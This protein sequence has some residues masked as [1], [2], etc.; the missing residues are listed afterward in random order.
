MPSWEPAIRARMTSLRLTSAREQEIVDELSQHLEDLWR[1][2]VA[3]GA[4]A[5][6]ATR[7][8]LEDFS[9]Q[10]LLA[11][12]LKPLR[13]SN[14]PAATVPAA[15]TGHMFSDLW[16][17]V[18]YAV[19]TL[20]KQ[21]SF[22]VAAVLTLA[23]G[24]GANAAVFSIVN[25]VLIRPLPYPDSGRL[26]AVYSRYQPATGFDFPYFPLSGPEFADLRNRVRSFSAI[27]AYAGATR[28]VTRDGAT[29]ERVVTMRVTAPFFDVLGVQP[30]RGR[31]FT[32]EE[33]QRTE[34][35]LA[36]LAYD[37]ADPTG[38]AVGSTIRLDDAPCE[39][40]GVMPRGFVFRDE[41]VRV[42]TTLFVNAQETPL[43]RQSHG[44]TAVA[45]LRDGVTAEQADAELK[46]VW[47]YWSQIYAEHY[48]KGHFA[49]LRP[50]HE[51]IVGGQ[52]NALVVLGGAVVFV[53]LIVCVNISALLIS[54][55]EARRREI[56]VRHALGANRRRLVR[57]LV[58]EAMV[59]AGVGGTA[60]LLVANLLLQALLALSPQRQ[61]AT[62]PIVLDYVTFGYAGL[63]IILAGFFIGIIPALSATGARMQETLRVDSRT[64]T[65]SLRVLVARSLLV[66]GQLA[67]SV[68]LL[69]G[70]LLL[71]RS[72]QDL[73]R[74]DLGISPD[75]LLTFSVSVPPGRQL[76]AAA[77]RRTLVAMEQRLAALP[78]VEAVGT[79]T[80]L[81]MVSP[82]PADN[83]AI[84]GRPMPAPGELQWNA[85]YIMA[86]PAMFRTLGMSLKRGRLI[87]DTDLPGRP[88]VAVINET[89]ARRYWP[90]EDPIDKSIRYYPLETS[91]L[92]RIVGVV[93]DVRSQGPSQPAPPSVYVP[94]AQAPRPVYQGRAVT[95]MVR[96]SGDPNAM[97]PAARAAIAAVDAGLPLAGVQ[98]MSQVVA[99]ST[100]QPRFAT[101][102]MS[103]FAAVAF[104]L[105]GLGLYGMLSYG[106]EQRVRE[107]GVRVALG[108]GRGEIV[109][110]IVGQG[111]TLALI[112]VAIGIPAAWAVTRLLGDVLSGVSTSDPLAYLAVAA[113]LVVAALLAT[114]LPARRATQVDPLVALRAE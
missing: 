46:S 84:D 47:A 57:Q 30:M 45:R 71:I 40:I 12:Y 93:G 98:P 55:S 50:L 3:G 48:A 23:L 91:P 70:A 1:E 56:A 94:F 37:A 54:R 51:D 62:Q 114:Y 17:D 104:F 25:A 24:I 15:P 33:A 73:Q 76:D 59:L 2:L 88:L 4:S 41:R 106:V 96:V 18:R 89:T 8:A 68:I 36:V 21:P 44:L 69:V 66:V 22:S 39:V 64:A 75:R 26:L 43:I 58:A 113:M 14:T 60:G 101:L 79:T 61:P 42:W 97:V 95:F 63:L 85:R 111:M 107:I 82:G 83:F 109:R 7:L 5:E 28:N 67:L 13:Q 81:P 53:L 31:T 52:R 103:F 27:A 38:A 32:E 78:G 90:N 112:G 87:D 6:E 100:G 11:R 99:D 35:C 86:T 77:A 10:D 102:V 74:V 80:N 29:A 19:R 34:G 65:A 49:V 105:S 108:A 16:Q 92:I 72:Y 110:L 20:R 9:E